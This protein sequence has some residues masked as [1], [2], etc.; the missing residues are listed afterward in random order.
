[1]Q[2]QPQQQQQQRDSS[3]PPLPLFPPSVYYVF[4]DCYIVVVIDRVCTAN[5]LHYTAIQFPYSL[6]ESSLSLPSMLPRP[7]VANDIVALC[8]ACPVSSAS[9]DVQ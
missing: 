8:T 1:M 9:I 2:R 7:S 3:P 6:S 5:S 4:T